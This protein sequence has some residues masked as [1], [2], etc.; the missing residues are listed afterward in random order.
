MAVMRSA[1]EEVCFGG[2]MTG[3]LDILYHI[4]TIMYCII[5]DFGMDHW[6][7]QLACLCNGYND[8]NDKSYLDYLQIAKAKQQVFTK[9]LKKIGTSHGCI[10]FKTPWSAT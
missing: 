1:A 3:A 6:L 10:N 2:I 4:K 5:K 9:P 8:P 7:G